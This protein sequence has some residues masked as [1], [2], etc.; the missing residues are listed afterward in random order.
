MASKDTPKKL[1]QKRPESTGSISRCRLC[2]SVTDSKYCKNLFRDHKKTV[3]RNAER[4]YGRELLH[5]D[6]LPHLICAPCERRLNNAIKFKAVI[7]ETQCI[8]QEDVQEDVQAKHCVDVSPSFPKPPRK[9]TSVGTL[10]HH[11]IDFNISTGESESSVIP[12]PLNVSLFE[13]NIHEL[14]I[15]NFNIYCGIFINRLE[16]DAIRDRYRILV[17]N[18]L[19]EHFPAFAM[20]RNYLPTSTSCGY[21]KAMASKSEVLTMPI[22]MKDEKKYS[23]CVDVLDQ[24]E[25]W[26]QEI[27]TAAGL[28]SPEPESSEDATPAIGTTSRPDQPASHV[29]PVHI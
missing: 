4:I 27:Y 10:R 6:S 19:F 18:I 23:D 2:N 25:K 11:S 5:S 29:P 16:F 9:V 22:V 17:A 21:P 3:L 7:E 28:C 13:S 1:H 24:L 26:T 12:S 8:L 14:T 15:A 20:F